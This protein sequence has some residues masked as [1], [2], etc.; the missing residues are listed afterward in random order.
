MA[1][2]QEEVSKA[3]T[4]GRS[5]SFEVDGHRFNIERVGR[6][7][8]PGSNP[9]QV[10]VEGKIVHE[11][12]FPQGDDD[13]FF[14]MLIESKEKATITDFKVEKALFSFANLTKLLGPAAQIPLNALL[15]LEGGDSE[16][17]AML[18]IVQAIGAAVADEYF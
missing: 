9:K 3:L 5:G 11:F 16:T 8:V 14:K 1:S 13:I 4:V 18:K 10:A 12:S 2:L 15:H 6:G 7:K 17:L